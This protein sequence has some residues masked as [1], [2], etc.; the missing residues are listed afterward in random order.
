MN[1][2]KVVIAFGGGLDSGA[3]VEYALAHGLAPILYQIDYG[4]KARVGEQLAAEYYSEKYGLKLVTALLP[5]VYIESPLVYGT[6]AQKHSDNYIMGRNLL[7]ASMALSFASS[8]GAGEVWFGFHKEPAGSVFND[9]QAVWLDHL[10]SLTR[11]LYGK[12]FPRAIA[13]FGNRE[14]WDYLSV[15]V[16]ENDPSIFSHTF[17][18]YESTGEQEC[19]V[20]T[21]CKAKSVL[22]EEVM[23][24]VRHLL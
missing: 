9:A 2:G 7:F 17:S 21:H 22:H 14:R 16:V 15:V 1:N 18:C 8:I 23:R 19:G 12:D 5:H 24:H 10:N 11:S 13:P 20:C 6:M 3:M 4:Q